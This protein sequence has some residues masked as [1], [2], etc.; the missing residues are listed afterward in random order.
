[1]APLRIC[2]ALAAVLVCAP[3]ALA[4]PLPAITPKSLN[5]LAF[6][7]CNHQWDPAYHWDDIANVKPDAF[8]WLGDIAYL[9]I[10][11]IIWK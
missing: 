9:D 2:P 6:G 10:P 7:S 1:M 5:R 11:K 3:L 8:L 4:L